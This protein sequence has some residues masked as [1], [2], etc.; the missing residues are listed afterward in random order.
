MAHEV[1]RTPLEVSLDLRDEVHRGTMPREQA[2]R[3]LTMANELRDSEWAQNDLV[4]QNAKRSLDL[5]IAER[6]RDQTIAG[7]PWLMFIV[8][9]LLGALITVIVSGLATTLAR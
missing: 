7:H 1:K 5:A 8:G 4:V 6:E 2:Q 9:G 3:V